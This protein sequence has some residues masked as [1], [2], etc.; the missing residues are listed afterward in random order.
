MLRH[1][2]ISLCTCGGHIDGARAFFLF[3]S[4][5]SSASGGGSTSA[6]ARA[7]ALGPGNIARTL[8]TSASG[9]RQGEQADKREKKKI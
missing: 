1:L 8:R 5:L 2:S 3:C 4:R 7:L 6:R 9:D